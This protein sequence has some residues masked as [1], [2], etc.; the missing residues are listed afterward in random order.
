MLKYEE[1]AIINLIEFYI[2]ANEESR[3]LIKGGFFYK[4]SNFIVNVVPSLGA[5][6][7]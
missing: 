4:R 7:T 1:K 6:S 2:E 3:P 5:D